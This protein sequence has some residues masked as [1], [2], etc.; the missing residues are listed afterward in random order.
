MRMDPATR[1]HNAREIF[2]LDRNRKYEQAVT[3]K[4]RGLWYGFGGAW[5]E[6]CRSE[7]P[8]WIKPHTYEVEP[9]GANLLVLRTEADLLQF[10]SDYKTNYYEEN[11]ERIDGL[12][13]IRGVDWPRLAVEYDGIEIP[14]YLWQFRLHTEFLWF[15]GWDIA[16]GCIW[17]VDKVDLKRTT[18]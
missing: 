16:S 13:I 18:K 9:N 4:P 17:M 6:W 5:I 14:V 11:G 3:F 12:K 8:Q 15:Y 10:N 1:Y 2:D 7:M